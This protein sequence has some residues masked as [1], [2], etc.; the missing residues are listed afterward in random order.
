MEDDSDLTIVE[1][2][3]FIEDSVEDEIEG[4]EGEIPNHAARML[5]NRVA[6]LNQTLVNIEMARANEDRDDPTDETI[7]DAIEQDIVDIL[8]SI[9]AVRHEY[10]LDVAGAFVERMEFM[11]AFKDF[12]AAVED[13]ESN[14]EIMEAFDEHMP[15]EFDMQ[16]PSPT[17]EAGTNVDAEDYD[18][19]NVDKS[20]A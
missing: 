16:D 5:M 10:D 20:F 14:E 2:M 1:M 4:F 17:I 7:T 18:H 3:E 12:E 11:Q 6:N 19:D 13:A 9:G 8:L 15:D